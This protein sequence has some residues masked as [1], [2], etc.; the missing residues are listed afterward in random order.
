MKHLTISLILAIII[1]IM[2]AIHHNNRMQAAQDYI[3]TLETNC[4]EIKTDSTY[5]NWYN[6]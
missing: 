3:D 4:S 5:Y 6:Y 1:I 2:L